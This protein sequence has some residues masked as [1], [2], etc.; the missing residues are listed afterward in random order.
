MYL[1][2]GIH[3]HVSTHINWHI[4]HIGIKISAKTHECCVNVTI[5]MP[6]KTQ[7]LFIVNGLNYFALSEGPVHASEMPFESRL[8][9]Q[10]M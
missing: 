4:L 9:C 3:I 7:Q 10:S 6:P 1:S 5:F 8:W 2:W